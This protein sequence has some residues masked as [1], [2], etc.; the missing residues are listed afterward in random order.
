MGTHPI[1][2]SD[3]D[4]LTE[5]EMEQESTES[6]RLTVDMG[7]ATLERV[8]EYRLKKRKQYQALKRKEKEQARLQKT[9]KATPTIQFKRAEHFLRAA[10]RSQSDRISMNPVD[11]VKLVCVVRVRTADGIGKLA[12]A[13]MKKLRVLRMYQCTFVKYNEKTH[14]L[15]KTAEPYITWGKPDVRTIREL[16]SKR[17]YAEVDG[18]PMVLNSNAAVE[19]AL[20][21]IDMLAIEDLIK[22]IVTVGD[23]FGKVNGFLQPL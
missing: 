19:A 11:D 6:E 13:A 1:F 9:K 8:P 4:C 23:N 3:F 18:K 15:L 12:L 7:P 20:G 22:E 5:R 2:E 14:R 17:G 16:L 21:S 10:K